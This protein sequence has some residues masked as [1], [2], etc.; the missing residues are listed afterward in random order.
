MNQHSRRKSWADEADK[1]TL[2]NLFFVVTV[3]VI[4]LDLQQLENSVA[5]TLA[6]K[7]S[8]RVGSCKKW[9]KLVECF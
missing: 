6:T 7:H 8:R 9:R 3:H 4:N 2:F 5:P 1:I